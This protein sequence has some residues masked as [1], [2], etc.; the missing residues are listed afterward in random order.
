MSEQHLIIS[1]FLHLFLSVLHLLQRSILP[2]DLLAS[3]TFLYLFHPTNR[4]FILRLHVSSPSSVLLPLPYA[5]SV[6]FGTA[7]KPNA[8]Q[9]WLMIME[10]ME[11]EN[12][13]CWLLFLAPRASTIFGLCGSVFLVYWMNITRKVLRLGFLLFFD[14]VTYYI[15]L[16]CW[17]IYQFL[18]TNLFIL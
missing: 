16:C 14:F 18:V 11:E 9:I 8:E 2:I 4:P 12:S 13:R 5:G 1:P 3:W 10:M 17:W 15:S 7:V 6:W